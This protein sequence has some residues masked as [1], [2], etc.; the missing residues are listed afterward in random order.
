MF[1]IHNLRKNPDLKYHKKGDIENDDMT[2]SGFLFEK[3]TF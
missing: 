1:A 3:I 2:I